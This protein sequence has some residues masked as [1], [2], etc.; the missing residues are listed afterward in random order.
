[1]RIR[2]GGL[3]LEVVPEVYEPSDD[4]FLLMKRAKDLKGSVLDV[5]CGSGIQSLAN[6]SENPGN[7][8]TGVDINP[9]AVECSRY[10][11]KL[12]KIENAGFS[13]SDLFEK[14]PKKT[15]DG[16]IFNPPYL[17]TSRQ[18]KI[19]GDI[20]HAFDGGRDGRLV[21]DRFLLEFEKHLSLDGTLLLL[22]SSLNGL[23]KT[24][25]V[26]ENQDF[27]M[28]ILEE[29]SFFFEKLYVIEA[30]RK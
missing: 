27:E 23:E 18:E 4:S 2:V 26:L 5:G 20:N 8:V 10:N 3:C 7:S 29:A 19:K 21:V 16:I 1:M 30:K 9:R 11:A 12:N 24:E 22:Q 25:R 28:R 6:A 14:I 15:F 13:Q 17:P